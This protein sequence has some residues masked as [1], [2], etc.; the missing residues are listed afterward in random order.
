MRL[1]DVFDT[2]SHSFLTHHGGGV[3]MGAGGRLV[4]NP[5]P[6]IPHFPHAHSSSLQTAGVSAGTILQPFHD[7]FDTHPPS[8]ASSGDR[9]LWH[10]TY[11]GLV[12][13]VH[14]WSW[15]LPKH[16]LL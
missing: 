1:T 7:T 9:W 10:S 4:E 11:I 6:Q 15:P 13:A 5:R 8:V 16:L 3:R 14:A 2:V 12:V